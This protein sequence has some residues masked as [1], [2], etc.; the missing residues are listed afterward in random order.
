MAVHVNRT[1]H[2]TLLSD[3]TSGYYVLANLF[4][5]FIY[6]FVADGLKRNTSREE[7]DLLQKRYFFVQNYFF[8]FSI[9]INFVISNRLKMD[10]MLRFH[11]IEHKLK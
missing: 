8:H 5:H 1:P 9:F 6:D 10:C 11:Q 7:K 4:A 2:T 3:N